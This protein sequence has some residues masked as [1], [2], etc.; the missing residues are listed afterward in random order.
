MKFSDADAKQ[1]ECVSAS[2]IKLCKYVVIQKNGLYAKIPLDVAQDYITIQDNRDTS[3][4]DT[5]SLMESGDY[6]ERF[7]AEYIQLR[8]RYKSLKSMV[9]KWDNGKLDFTPTCPRA[10]YDLQLEYM[11]K[12]K[13]ILEMRAK[14]EGIT[15]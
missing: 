14:M 3:L 15:L 10:T 6:K 11:R 9:E 1:E 13:D 8:I 5:V 4:A 2:A 7:M 12:Y